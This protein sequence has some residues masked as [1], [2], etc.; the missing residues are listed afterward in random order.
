M[1]NNSCAY[2][3]EFT[4]TFLPLLQITFSVLYGTLLSRPAN[5][6]VFKILKLHLS[7]PDRINRTVFSWYFQ[8]GWTL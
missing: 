2:L 6:F 1:Y 7:W 5:C 3:L 8:I 4:G